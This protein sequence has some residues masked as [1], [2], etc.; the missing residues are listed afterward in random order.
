MK[1]ARE[2][3][4]GLGPSRRELKCFHKLGN[5]PANVLHELSALS[6]TDQNDLGTD[7]Y[8]LP[9]NFDLANT[10]NVKNQQ[11]RQVL[12]QKAKHD[13]SSEL[14]YS[15]WEPGLIETRKYLS[16]YFQQVY[17]FRLSIM[18][19]NHHIPWHIDTDTSIS[20]RAQIC[21]N[22]TRSVFMWKTKEGIEELRMNVGDLYFINTGW[23]HTV[24]GGAEVR[25][26]AIF[27]FQFSDLDPKHQQKLRHDVP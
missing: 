24:I 10:F 23:S 12:F 16:T 6:K 13:P 11:Y 25:E 5:V 4:R 14:E 19:P 20:C 26:V 15:N 3:V 17:R 1:N 21:L 9:S 2:R 18:E 8:S 27:G 22:A 7:D